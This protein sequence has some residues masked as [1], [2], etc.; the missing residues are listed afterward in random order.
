M[1]VDPGQLENC[2]L[3]LAINARDAMPRGGALTMRRRMSWSMR[4]PRAGIRARGWGVPG[5][6]RD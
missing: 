4:K 3:N 1:R 6:H 5:H 2:L